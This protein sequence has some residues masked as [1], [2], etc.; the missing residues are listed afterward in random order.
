MSPDTKNQVLGIVLVFNT[1]TQQD[2]LVLV[3]NTRKRFPLLKF[4]GGRVKDRED[5][6]S[7]VIREIY[8][9][10]RIPVSTGVEECVHVG[11][12]PEIMSTRTNL[13]YA[14]DLFLFR[15]PE[16]LVD[17]RIPW[18]S[19]ACYEHNLVACRRSLSELRRQN[20]FLP[21]HREYLHRLDAVLEQGLFGSR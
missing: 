9:E 18:N 17:S 5:S 15:V 21:V 12:I 4:P 19:S 1:F 10:T 20:L 16:D 6:H 3:R 11:R 8:E 13:T 7:A 14:L 2:E